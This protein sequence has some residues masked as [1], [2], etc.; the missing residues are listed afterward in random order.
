MRHTTALLLALSL[1][2]CNR[3]HEET[4]DTGEP[5]VETE[6]T[7]ETVDTDDTRLVLADC[8]FSNLSGK[9]VRPSNSDVTI[10]RNN[11]H[12]TGEGVNVVRC[13]GLLS[14]NR[15]WNILGNADALDVDF[16]WSGS[17]DGPMIVEWNDLEGAL[18][19]NADAIDLAES[20]ATSFEPRRSTMR[21]GPT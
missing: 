7:E 20:S 2:G 4:A 16:D 15:I 18:H 3:T 21:A 12:H 17:G 10:V 1:L 9:A 13:T 6:E 14:S 19:S 5:V 8:T 11:I